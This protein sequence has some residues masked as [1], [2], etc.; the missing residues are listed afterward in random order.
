MP[1]A[2]DQQSNI[3]YRRSYNRVESLNKMKSSELRKKAKAMGASEEALLETDDAES[4]KQA[5]IDI[6]L[7]VMKAAR[8]STAPAQTP[9][10]SSAALPVRDPPLTGS[11]LQLPTNLRS[12]RHTPIKNIPTHSTSYRPISEATDTHQWQRQRSPDK[13]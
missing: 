1:Q 3:K 4:P 13:P 12:N 11:A 6:I 9:S 7:K 8:S 5:R 2:T 10:S